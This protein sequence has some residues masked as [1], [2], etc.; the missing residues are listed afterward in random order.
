MTGKARKRIKEIERLVHARV[1]DATP[2][3]KGHI[4]LTFS[5]GEVVISATPSRPFAN[6]HAAAD[7]KRLS[8]K[9]SK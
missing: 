2:T 5:R 8:R 4:R 3:G 7:I 1:L 9:G 6:K